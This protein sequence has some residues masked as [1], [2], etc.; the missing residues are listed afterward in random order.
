M[1]KWIGSVD[2]V[3]WR[4]DPVFFQ[5]MSLHFRDPTVDLFA[6]RD[7]RQTQSFFSRFL[8]SGAEAVDALRS[9]WPSGL[10][11]AFLPLLLIPRVI[12]KL[13]E[14]LLIAPHW[15]RC[16]WFADLVTLSVD[17]P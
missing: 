4:L 8:S 9:L 15:P 11:Y 17:R 12:R 16:P 3:E 10:L 13:L 6:T 7:N 2:Q 14:V 5:E 1:S